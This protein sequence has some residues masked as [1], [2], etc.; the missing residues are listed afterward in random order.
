MFTKK[1]PVK[2]LL[3]FWMVLLSQ[4]THSQIVDYI[5][6]DY[7][8]LPLLGKRVALVIGNSSYS[9]KKLSNACYNAYNISAALSKIGFEVLAATD[10]DRKQVLNKI[11]EYEKKLEQQIEISLVY[12]IGYGFHYLNN[13]NNY[14]L[15]ISAKLKKPQDMI[16]QTVKDKNL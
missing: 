5:V 8:S 3:L 12:Y 14:L 7:D 1:T 11:N 13:G 4:L 2:G 15:P 16:F 6:Y 9:N 10:V